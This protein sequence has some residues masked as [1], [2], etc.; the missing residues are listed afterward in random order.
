MD[1]FSPGDWIDSARGILPAYKAS[2]IQQHLDQGCGDCLKSSKTWRLIVEVSSREPAYRP[3]GSAVEASKGA[4]V[5][6][7]PGRWLAEI[8]Q[9]AQL[10]FDSFSQPSLATVRAAAQSSRQLVHEAEPFVIDLRL[11]SDPARK[12]VSL[13]GQ[14]LNSK[15]PDEATGKIDVIVLSGE[16]LVKRTS[17]NDVGEFDLDFNVQ[18]DL[19]LVI[20]IRGQRAIGI[21][22]PTP[23][24]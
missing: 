22:L 4:F 19:Q 1:H 2:L 13:M 16:Q 17:T 20:N 21:N 7:E 15:N 5:P 14:I 9:F 8:A 23:E 24:S 10:L 18:P 11:D 6:R 3:P 12:R